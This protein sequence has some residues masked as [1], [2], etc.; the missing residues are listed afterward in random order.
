MH[1]QNAT[2]LTVKKNQP[3]NAIGVFT[4]RAAVPLSLSLSLVLWIP[5]PQAMTIERLPHFPPGREEGDEASRW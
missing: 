3:Y 1:S 2:I 4:R 5:N